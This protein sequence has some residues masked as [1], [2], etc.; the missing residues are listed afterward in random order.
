MSEPS[1]L[2]TVEYEVSPLTRPPIS[3]RLGT[4]S[5]VVDAAACSDAGRV[6]DINEDYYMVCRIRRQLELL[7]TNL[8]P[9]EVPNIVEW[10]GYI[11]AVA[12]G[13]GGHSAGE[14]ASQLALKKGLDLVL[15]QANWALVMNEGEKRLLFTRLR[16][17]FAEIDRSLIREVETD[18]ALKGMATT[19]T[20]VY[21]VGLQAFLIHVGDSRAYRFR[22]GRL[23]QMTRDH[24]VAQG[25]L[26]AGK[27]TAEEVRFR[28]RRHVLTNV[29]SGRPGEVEPDVSSFELADRDCILLCSDGLNDM[30]SDA[31][32][33]T[34]LSQYRNPADAVRALIQAANDRGGRDNVTAVLAQYEVRP[35]KA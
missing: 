32:I 21:T 35:P 34:V 4:V 33:A 16:E 30:L 24:T 13:L 7:A 14:R 18:P 5:V 1:P 9:S 8:P 22:E 19:L 27:I 6:R 29:L 31:E 23:E 28:S 17:Y 20:V 2:E 25:M 26:D 10:D 15:S 11:F 3:A 12:D